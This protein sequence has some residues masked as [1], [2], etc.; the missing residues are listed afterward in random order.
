[1]SRFFSQES[2]TFSQSQLNPAIVVPL[3]KFSCSLTNEGNT[4]G[5]QWTHYSRSDLELVIQEVQ[6]SSSENEKHLLMKVVAGAE[7]LVC[8]EFLCK[9]FNVVTPFKEEQNLNDI[10]RVHKNFVLSPDSEIPV[11][12]VV[13]PPLLALRYPKLNDVRRL[14]FRFR[15]DSDFNRVLNILINLGLTP[16]ESLSSGPVLRSRPPTADPTCSG[17]SNGHSSAVGYLPLTPNSEFK[18]PMG[19][20]S[21]GSML[22]RPSSSYTSRS[23]DH[24]CIRPQSAMSISSFMPQSKPSAEPLNRAQSL[25]VSQF[26]REQRQ[27]QS[28]NSILNTSDKVPSNGN[29]YVNRILLP[30]PEESQHRFSVSPFFETQRK[31]CLPDRFTS[32]SS[33]NDPHN[34]RNKTHETALDLFSPAE[35]RPLP[36]S[37]EYPFFGAPG[38]RPISLP[39]ENDI[40]L[41]LPIPP[42][43]QL[44]FATLKDPLRSKSVSVADTS[45]PVQAPQQRKRPLEKFTRENT[46]NG[47]SITPTKKPAKRRVAS[48]KGTTYLSEV[49]GLSSNAF[50]SKDSSASVTLDIPMQT[51][52]SPPLEA[53]SIATPI[54]L[55]RTPLK[56]QAEG[57]KARQ[58]SMPTLKTPMTLK[59]VDRSTQTQTL[60]GRDH[61]AALKPASNIPVVDLQSTRPT[62]SVL[63]DDLDLVISRY[64]SGSRVSLPSNYSDVPDDKRHKMLNDFIIKNLENDD[65]LKLAEDMDVSWR[66][67]G[68]AR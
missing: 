35:D 4:T 56:L 6:V 37:T 38:K 60:S 27:I 26:E 67:I 33:A 36:R 20:D 24:L 66:R 64:T 29:A 53:R 32:F 52:K 10:V 41:G 63:Q 18:V 11:R 23:D 21:A 51:E 3:V 34:S 16:T 46:S 9:A 14:Q 8:D 61:T 48:R 5:V 54:A 57:I 31:H 12:V 50:P 58:Q 68:L 39:A 7:Y 43:R 47:R 45:R 22:Q 30:K 25:Y 49:N 42:K 55:D 28:S 59:M 2:L 15:G 44:P 17:V 19:P 13:K 65:F 1:M 62:A 40:C